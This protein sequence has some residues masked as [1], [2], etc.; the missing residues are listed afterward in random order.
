MSTAIDFG[1]EHSDRILRHGF[2]WLIHAFTSAGGMLHGYAIGLGT[3]L[4][5]CKA[6]TDA[7]PNGSKEF[8]VD[9]NHPTP[10]SVIFLGAATIGALPPVAAAIA[11]GIGR[12]NAIFLSSI[13]AVVSSVGMAVAPV[14]N[15]Q[16]LWF[17][18]AGSGIAVGVLS[19]VV[20]LYQSEV[21]PPAIRGRLIS[22]FQLALALGVL[23]AYVCLYFIEQLQEHP[24][25][26]RLLP[27]LQM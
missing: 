18:R 22:T 23:T 8:L 24:N 12:R 15:R 9:R 10:E 11:D 19:V 4:P 1:T 7:F 13:V 16:W 3:I 14:G 25:R 2:V 5:A 17:C 26:W 6:F 27:A 20:P 21:A